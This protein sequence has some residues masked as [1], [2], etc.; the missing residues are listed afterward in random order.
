MRIV[1]DCSVPVCDSDVSVCVCVQLLY[2]CVKGI[3]CAN[4][5]IRKHDV[6]TPNV[7]DASTVVCGY[8][9]H[10]HWRFRLHVKQYV[11]VS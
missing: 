2:V 10:V 9:W 5:A 8:V 7:C 3:W 4:R 6:R 1:A 11:A